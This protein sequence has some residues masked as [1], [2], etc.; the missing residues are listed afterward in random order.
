MLLGKIQISLSSRP[1][2]SHK[3]LDKNGVMDWMCASPQNSYVEALIHSVAVFGEGDSK[4]VIKVKWGHKG[5][6]LVRWD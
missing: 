5:G 2:L 1:I 6:A 4:E 3:F